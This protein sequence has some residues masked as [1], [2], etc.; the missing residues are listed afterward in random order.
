MKLRAQLQDFLMSANPLRRCTMRPFTGHQMYKGSPVGRV[1]ATRLKAIG[2]IFQPLT[3]PPSPRFHEAPFPN[4]A[5]RQF[6]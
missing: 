1:A 3:A 6:G 4:P 2:W 5:P